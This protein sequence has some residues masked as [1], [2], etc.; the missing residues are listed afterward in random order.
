MCFGLSAILILTKKC[1]LDIMDTGKS[2]FGQPGGVPTVVIGVPNPFGDAV[3]P[4]GPL[5]G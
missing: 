2:I 5:S 4:F 1:G 3:L